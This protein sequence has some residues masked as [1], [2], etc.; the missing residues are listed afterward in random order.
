MID[1]SPNARAEKFEA[2]KYSSGKVLSL[3]DLSNL[4]IHLADTYRYIFNGRLA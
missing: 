3:H 1:G 4:T 2:A